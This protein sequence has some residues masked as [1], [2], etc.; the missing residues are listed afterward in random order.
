M[1]TELKIPDPRL[2][3]G[4][5]AIGGPF[6]AGEQPLGWGPVDDSESA[7]AIR[8]GL[9]SGVRL[10]DTADV[11]GAGHSERI[12]GK[13]LGADR[14]KVLIATKWGNV[15]DEGSKQLTGTD[16]SSGYVREA[17]EASLRRLGTDL[18]D[19]F[20]LHIGDLALDRLPG[21]VEELD[22]LRASGKIKSF[23]WS[24]DD[25]Q[26]AES[27]LKYPGA[28][29]VQFELNVVHDNAPMVSLLEGRE[30]VGLIRGPLAMG[31][32]S[33]KYSTQQA[34]NQDDVRNRTPAWMKYF[35]SG[36]PTPE[37]QAR[38]DSIRE[39]LKTGGRTLV[40]GALAWL[41][42]RSRVLVPIPGFRTATQAKELA[43][44]W[45]L[46]PLTPTE[47]EN[48]DALLNND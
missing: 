30:K 42:A 16:I 31:L 10:F 48:I 33:G 29:I 24:T 43:E 37:Y 12:L 45:A 28:E 23:G 2:G 20:Q 19:I 4:C 44:A 9:D 46:G 40:Q 17:C 38:F 11:Y 7:R 35:K 39:A 15:F 8:T 3:L 18:I 21:V 1:T 13:T 27:V 6:W 5:W 32:L 41:W 14:D 25:P 34:S 47:M 26:R 36:V 22:K